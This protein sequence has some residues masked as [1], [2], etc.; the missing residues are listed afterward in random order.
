MEKMQKQLEKIQ[1]NLMQSK[2]ELPIILKIRMAEIILH[3]I[4]RRKS[5]GLFVILGWSNKWKKFADTPDASQD[6]FA[7]HNINVKRQASE[8]TRQG[9][10]KTVNFDGAILVDSAGNIVHSGAMIE[11]LR[12]K[13]AADKINPG[14]FA[15]LSTQFG[16]MQKVHMRHLA[17]ITASYM[18]KGTTVFT[19]SE[20]TGH[21]HIFENGRILYSTFSGENE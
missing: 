16:F 17:A 18:L 11:G 14:R 19:V 12:P 6:I 20:E 7:G 10:V 4:K 1:G 9:I 5:F 8:K 3:L 21:F 13:V 15:D 2:N